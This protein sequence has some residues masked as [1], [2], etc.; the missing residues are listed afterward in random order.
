MTAESDYLQSMIDRKVLYLTD[1][2][3]NA[4]L[5]GGELDLG[6]EISIVEANQMRTWFEPSGAFGAHLSPGQKSY[7]RAATSSFRETQAGIRST[8]QGPRPFTTRT[9]LTFPRTRYGRGDRWHAFPAAAPNWIDAVPWA[10]GPATEIRSV[11]ISL[12]PFTTTVRTTPP[13][14]PDGRIYLRVINRAGTAATAS[15]FRF[16][17]ESKQLIGAGARMEA[18][19]HPS[20]WIVSFFLYMHPPG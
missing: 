16:D 6:I 12:V 15:G 3:Y 11:E 18:I 1:P 17:A 7:I 8:P 9:G 4:A 20:I 19:D 10:T 2:R 13:P 5:I 14:A